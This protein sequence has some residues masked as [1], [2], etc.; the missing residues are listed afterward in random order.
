MPE[1]P[2]VDL[3]TRFVLENPWPLAMP[4]TIA[5]AV[6]VW[7]TLTGG[8]SRALGVGLGLIG[9]A[10]ALCVV[11]WMVQTSGERAKSLARQ[12]VA[13]VEAEDVNGAITLLTSD[14]TLAY[15]SPLN[16]GHD[17]GVISTRL[18][19]LANE[20]VIASNS[21]T[22]LDGFSESAER[23]VCHLSCVTQ[24]ENAMG[25]GPVRSRWVLWAT[26]QGDG[27]WRISRITAVSFNGEEASRV[28]R[29]NP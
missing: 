18:Q 6:V 22:R 10:I 9:V 26:P 7:R 1:P 5:G 8:R 27:T 2:F 23:G 25:F 17:L 3:I 14:A 28:A 16:P 19:G 11:A 20:F 15:D 12:F 4:L 13:A 21:I 29:A 24:V